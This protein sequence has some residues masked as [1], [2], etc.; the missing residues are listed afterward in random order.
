[1]VHFPKISQMC[2]WILVSLQ[3]TLLSKLICAHILADTPLSPIGK[4][5]PVEV[6]IGMDNSHLLLPLEV[7]YNAK[8]LNEPYATRSV[9][10]WAL[11]GHLGYSTLSEITSNFIQL[12]HKLDR[13]WEIEN[14]DFDDK[15]HSVEDRKVVELWDREI[16]HENGHYV[17]PIPWRNG[18]ADLPNNKFITQCRLDSLTRRLE[19]TDLTEVY[20][21]NI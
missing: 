13:M 5:T 12:E 14:D 1:M 2:W 21:Q 4:G 8:S 16:K 3:N 10:G 11:Q 18:H 6:A 20:D 17:L 19:K 9:F 7:R 15:L